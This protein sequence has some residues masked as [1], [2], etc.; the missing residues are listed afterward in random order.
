M[1]KLAWLL[2]RSRD[3]E[4]SVVAPERKLVESSDRVSAPIRKVEEMPPAGS[5]NTSP[6]ST[7]SVDRTWETELAVS[8][9][10]R[11]KSLGDSMP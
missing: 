8:L 10:R 9:D 4:R 2:K 1:L 5:S 6:F 7:S 3:W 11:T